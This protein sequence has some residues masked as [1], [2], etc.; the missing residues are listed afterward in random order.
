MES[1]TVVGCVGHEFLHLLKEHFFMLPVLTN[2]LLL[3]PV[4]NIDALGSKANLVSS[5]SANSERDW[6]CFMFLGL[7]GGLFFSFRL[8]FTIKTLFKQ[9]KMQVC[10][11]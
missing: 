5:C 4:T 8:Q 6:I 1:G 10:E 2:L 9:I 3:P 7:V 11:I